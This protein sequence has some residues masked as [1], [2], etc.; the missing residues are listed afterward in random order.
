MSG[1]KYSYFQLTFGQEE[2][3]RRPETAGTIDCLRMIE[4]FAEYQLD[5][6]FPNGFAVPK[7]L[8]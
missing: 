7:E 2:A 5:P 1:L 3:D 4:R 8:V 6:E